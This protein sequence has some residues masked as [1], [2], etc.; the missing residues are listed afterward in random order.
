MNARTERLLREYIRRAADLNRLNESEYGA[1]YDEAAGTSGI[2]GIQP[3][4]LMDTFVGPFTDAFKTS[5]AAVK[6]ITTD[7]V[8]L[9]HVAFRAV[10]ST[11]IPVLG[12]RYDDIFDARDAKM[13]KI[14][15]EYAD[16]F[17]RTDA[18]LGSGD[19][20]LF[21]FMFN[22]GLI[23]GSA[24]ALKAP[25]ATKELLSV[26][27]GGVSDT[28]ISKSSS[29][30]KNFQ[31]KIL[32]GEKYSEKVNKR[33]REEEIE[34]FNNSLIEKLRGYDRERESDTQTEPD[35][36]IKKVKKSTSKKTQNLNPTY[37]PE[38]SL[39]NQTESLLLKTNFL[40]LEQ[41]DS[42]VSSDEIGLLKYMLKNKEIRQEISSL[43]KKNQEFKEIYEK[44]S[45]VEDE[46]LEEAE[47]LAD[48]IIKKTNSLEALKKIA[49]K[50]PEAIEAI[51][52]IETIK[53]P[54]EKQKAIKQ[55]VGNIAASSKQIFM[56]TLNK[57]KQQFPEGSP[58][59]EKYAAAFEKLK[60]L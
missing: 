40:L 9:L 36:K 13:K 27:T 32:T 10:I 17:R 5:V 22:P 2:G 23:L 7:A 58:Q 30:W 6:G 42:K 60:S 37:Y 31:E 39:N 16:V 20:K 14:K 47:A 41:D 34:K 3:G 15:D 45:T 43:V 51:K 12:S 19:A 54:E 57:R 26:A 55:L 33:K 1:Y 49:S 48:M 46:T 38:Y 8:T 18:A 25:A 59:Y 52:K 44:I 11:I 29:M 53:N 4:G 24:A 50:N 21:A 35:K 28:A 56:A